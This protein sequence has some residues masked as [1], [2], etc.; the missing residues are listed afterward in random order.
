MIIKSGGTNE[1]RIEA[2]NNKWIL[3]EKTGD[4]EGPVVSFTGAAFNFSKKKTKFA[5]I[6]RADS[7][8]FI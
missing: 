2:L 8:W 6:T 1:G 7:K 4:R 5:G 3:L